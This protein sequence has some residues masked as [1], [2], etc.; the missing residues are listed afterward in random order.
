MS[1]VSREYCQVITDYISAEWKNSQRVPMNVY[2]K[3]LDDGAAAM[4][5]SLWG[6]TLGQNIT[7]AEYG[8]LGYL[9]ESSGTLQSALE[10]L[11]QFD[12][13]VA[14]IGQ[15]Q[16]NIT[17]EI[18]TLTWMPYFNNRHA[19]LRNMTAWIATVRRLTNKPL[20]PHC[21]YFQDNFNESEL[22][23]LTHWFGCEVKVLQ[24]TNSI[25]FNIA[26]LA[27][28]IV[29]RNELVNSHLLLATQEAKQL[30]TNNHGWLSELQPVL[31]SADLHTLT[32]SSL[33]ELLCMSTRTLQRRLTEKS[34]NFS[35]LID[36]ERKRRFQQFSHKMR[37]QMLSD[38][39]GYSEQAS[40][41][42]AVKRWFNL[43]P[44]E[45][46]RSAKLN[47]IDGK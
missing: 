31:Q 27:M 13:T 7:S 12:K 43:S 3:G 30:Y 22:N 45:Y 36:D 9:V 14:D 42:K 21:I 6:F 15:V 23:T 20:T 24:N 25:T 32:V 10:A 47:L 44:S 1:D 18:A 29:T 33:A 34:T 19:V 8:L 11:L 17:G 39:L 38:L 41:N 28:P 16:F 5:N 37:K 46:V 4:Q 40:L 2:L 26:L 35:Q